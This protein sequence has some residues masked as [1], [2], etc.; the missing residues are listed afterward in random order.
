MHSGARFLRFHEKFRGDLSAFP[1]DKDLA[2]FVN[3]DTVF[4][5]LSNGT[6][7]RW[8]RLTGSTESKER[9]KDGKLYTKVYEVLSMR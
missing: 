7:L 6:E 4:T 3:F 5:Y 8:R 2:E 9:K 1:F